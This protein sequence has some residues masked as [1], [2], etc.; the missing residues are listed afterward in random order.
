M[1]RNK[2]L[3]VFCLLGSRTL[4]AKPGQSKDDIGLFKTMVAGALGGFTFWTLTFP[5]DVA[6]SRIQVNNSKEN[7]VLMM[8]RIW[9]QEGF[10]QLYNGLLPTLVRTIPATAT[11][12]VTYEYTKKGLHH[13]F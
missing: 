12:F 6:K 1:L 5:A 9:R 13:L 8:A 2:Y 11:L 4:L 10:G 3:I 7:M